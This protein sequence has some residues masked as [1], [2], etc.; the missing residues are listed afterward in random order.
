MEENMQ[1][2]ENKLYTTENVEVKQP[3]TTYDICYDIYIGVST[4]TFVIIIIFMYRYLK[5]VFKRK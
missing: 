5:S 4:L 1:N 3:A 2:L